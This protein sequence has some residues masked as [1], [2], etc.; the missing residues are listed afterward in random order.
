[1]LR[2]GHEMD[3]CGRHVSIHVRL[4]VHACMAA[5]RSVRF[6]S[7]KDSRRQR[8]DSVADLMRPIASRRIGDF[9]DLKGPGDEGCAN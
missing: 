9:F 8:R 2:F 6:Q 1:M 4:G 5:F 3:I 7:A